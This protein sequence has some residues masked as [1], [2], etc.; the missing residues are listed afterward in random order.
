MSAGRGG[1]NLR[2]DLKPYIAA[3]NNFSSIFT[4]SFPNNRI[5]LINSMLYFDL[6]NILDNSFNRLTS[7]INHILQIC[8]PSYKKIIS[9][10]IKLTLKDKFVNDS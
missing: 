8:A 3:S 9:P 5:D 10:L 1:E 4:E 7:D 2:T 6:N